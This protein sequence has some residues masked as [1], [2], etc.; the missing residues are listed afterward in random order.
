MFVHVSLSAEKIC[1][2]SEMYVVVVV[3][4][5]RSYHTEKTARCGDTVGAV[6][7]E[8]SVECPPFLLT[9]GPCGRIGGNRSKAA[10]PAD[11]GELRKGEMG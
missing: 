9:L 10:V 3:T 2:V 11:G 7:F 5:S 4:R 1:Y 6:R 8:Y